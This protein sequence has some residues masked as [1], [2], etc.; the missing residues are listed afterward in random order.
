MTRG[1]EGTPP[2]GG[3]FFGVVP[4]LTRRPHPRGRGVTPASPPCV[5]PRAQGASRSIARVCHGSGGGNFVGAPFRV[6]RA[7]FRV[8]PGTPIPPFL[9]FRVGPGGKGRTLEDGREP[10]GFY[11][12]AFLCFY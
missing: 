2:G 12:Q 6:F 7:V 9:S 5:L 1:W 11:F 8:P 4:N 3:W 10:V